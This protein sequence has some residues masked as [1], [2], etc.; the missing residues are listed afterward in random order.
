MDAITASRHGRTTCRICEARLGSVAE[1]SDGRAQVRFRRIPE[2]DDERVPLESILDDA[3]LDPAA[4][5]VDQADLTKARVVRCT[6]V[7]LDDRR[8]VA[9]REGVEVERIVEGDLVWRFGHAAGYVAETTVL[10]PPRTVKSPTTVMR[11]GWQAATR[12]SRISLV[13]AS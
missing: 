9:R 8:D 2:L 10:M 6:D 11:R 13:T 5:A 3:A 4:A 7:L 12:S 1:A